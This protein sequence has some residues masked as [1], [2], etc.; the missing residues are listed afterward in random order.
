M[1]DILNLNDIFPNKYKTSCLIKNVI[2]STNNIICD[3]TYYDD[4]NLPEDFESMA[5][6]FNYPE[7][8]GNIILG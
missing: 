7:F 8:D 4:A 5:V 6:L 3:H 1:N 2:K